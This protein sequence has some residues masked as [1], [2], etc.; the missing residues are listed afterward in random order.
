[1]RT[2]LLA[3]EREQDVAA[4]ETLLQARGLGV[5][6]ARSGLEALEVARRESPYLV[7]SDVMLP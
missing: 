6:V 3:Y 2:V 5:L 1:M 7:V 4:V